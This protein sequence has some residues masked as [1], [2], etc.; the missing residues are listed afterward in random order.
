[1]KKQ[2]LVLLAL[3]SLLCL[4]FA[5]CENENDNNPGNGQNNINETT[6]FNQVTVRFVATTPSGVDEIP[7]SLPLSKTELVEKGGKLQA[8]ALPEI[9]GYTLDGW[10]ADD[11]KWSFEEMTVAESVTLTAKWSRNIHVV[12]F[13]DDSGEVID[14]QLAHYG[15]KIAVP[16]EPKKAES[17]F[18]GWFNGERLWNFETDKITD[19]ITLKAV[20]S[21]DITYNLNG[22][23]NSEN[24]PEKIYTTSEFPINI[25]APTKDGFIFTGWY[26]DTD[27]TSEIAAFSA[28]TPYT[29]YA[30][31]EENVVERTIKV[32]TA[33]GMPLSGLTVKIHIG[34]G[35]NV[36]SEKL[37]DA[38]GMVRF[39]L[40]E[41]G[42]YSV[43]ITGAPNGYDVKDGLT[44]DERYALEDE[45]VITLTSAPIEN[46]TFKAQYA[47]GDVMHDFT[48]TDVN[49]KSY[50][51]S[52][53]LEEKDMVMLNFWFK[54]CYYC[55]I[56]FP[57]INN[58]YNTYKNDVEILAINDYDS[59]STIQ[60]YPAYLGIDLTIPLIPHNSLSLSNFPSKGYP[61]TVIIDRY[62]VICAIIVG[63]IPY[64]YVWNNIF[65]HFTAENYEQRII[66]DLNEFA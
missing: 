39:F 3:L 49:G 32:I 59:I 11:L 1:M 45:T 10:Y 53:L 43:Q 51:L 15:T 20:W 6:A 46:G 37:T 19:D 36:Y 26:T 13:I 62:G 4:L 48:L 16:D 42:E 12:E 63:S 41:I 38:E 61:T 54:D 56:E 55:K 60:D 23:T 28:F 35:Y 24:N 65:E 40:P 22:G 57:H 2:L 5:S 58:A 30:K 7:D 34:D 18:V 64:E 14:A 25:E 17:S 31:W 27:F 50:T 9:I 44:K 47:L 33:G 8:P 52:E 66:T 21:A 29:V